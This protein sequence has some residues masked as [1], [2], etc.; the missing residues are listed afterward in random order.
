[1]EGNTTSQD[2]LALYDDAVV[3]VTSSITKSR[4]PLDADGSLGDESKAFLTG[5]NNSS[6]GG[7]VSQNALT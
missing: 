4:A 7:K 1:M 3:G 5:L 2:H 6:A